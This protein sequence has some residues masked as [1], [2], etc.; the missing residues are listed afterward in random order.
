MVIRSIW[1]EGYSGKRAKMELWRQIWS[2]K[3]AAS[4]RSPREKES[5]AQ[6]SSTSQAGIER[7]QC[8]QSAYFHIRG[9]LRLT[10]LKLAELHS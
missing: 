1:M 6:Q 8:A 7:Q 5:W 2:A 4:S 10:S 3:R 9:R